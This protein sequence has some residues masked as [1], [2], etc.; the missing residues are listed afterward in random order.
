MAVKNICD[1]CKKEFKFDGLIQSDE[2]QTDSHSY[3]E[4]KYFGGLKQKK[5]PVTSIPFFVSIKYKGWEK[6]MDKIDGYPSQIWSRTGRF[7]LCP[8]CMNEAID[9]LTGKDK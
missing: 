2:P 9:F 8:G 4:V 5:V 7:D 6:Y 3:I 1:R